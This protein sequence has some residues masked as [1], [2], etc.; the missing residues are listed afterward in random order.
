MKSLLLT[1][2]I[3]ASIAI[4]VAI[5]AHTQVLKLTSLTP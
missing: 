2:A 5:N 3:V 1:V 4:K